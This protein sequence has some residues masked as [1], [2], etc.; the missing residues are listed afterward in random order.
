MGKYEYSFLSQ[1]DIFGIPPLFTIRGRRTFQTQIGSSLTIL[2]I[3]LILIYMSVFFNQMINHKS[4]DI[5]SIVYYDEIPEVELNKNDFLFVFSLQTK[6]FKNYIDESIYKVEAYYTQLTLKSNGIYNLENI[7][8]KITKCN[9]YNFELLPNYFNNITLNN[10]YC[11]ENFE[12]KI[13]KGD[14]MKEYWNYIRLNFSKCENSTKNEVLCKSINEINENLNGGYIGLF[15]LDNIFEPGKYLKPYRTYIKN[16]YKSFSIKYYEELFLYIKL[17][18][19]ITDSGYFFDNK[20]SLN[21]TAYDDIQNDI[22]FRDSEHFLSLTLCASPKKEIYKRSYIKLQTIFSNV[23]GMLKIILLLGEYSV[24]FIRILLYKNYILEFFNLDESEIRLK[25]VR[26]I[27]NLTKNNVAKNNI[28]TLFSNLSNIEIN[29]SSK[30]MEQKYRILSKDQIFL[31]NK[32]KMRTLEEKSECK[33]NILNDD[34]SILNKD[35]NKNN[36]LMSNEKNSVLKDNFFL[37]EYG[38]VKKTKSLLY[39]GPKKNLRKK[40]TMQRIKGGSIKE[41]NLIKREKISFIHDEKEKK[42]PKVTTTREKNEKNSKLQENNK[43]NKRFLSFRKVQTRKGRKMLFIPKPQLRVIKVPGFFSDFICKKN[44]L[45]TIKQVHENYKEIQF[46]LDIVHYLKSQNE[47]NI[48]EKHLF[49]E[50]QRK[51]L[52]FTYTFE[53]DFGLERKGY[54]YM[55]KHEKNKFDDDDKNEKLK[56]KISTNSN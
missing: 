55:I 48:I 24:Y 30:I 13:L 39:R 27:Y 15:I 2:C 8:L 33:S 31:N 38:N 28:E 44:T 16:L 18:E 37:N 51:S 43:G 3:I 1:L 41:G 47:L 53:A 23:G 32:M 54:D 12:D 45:K 19:I 34:N 4:P 7:P 40:E 29:T 36:N 49:T 25:E 9:E 10:L 50:E 14:Y 35:S 5:Q 42:K 56:N 21:F 17:I 26:K 22:D 6:E 46:L 20:K 52:S 11:L